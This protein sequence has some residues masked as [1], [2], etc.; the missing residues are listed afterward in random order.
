MGFDT[1]ECGLKAIGGEISFAD[2]YTIHTFK[3]SGTF[4]ILQLGIKNLEVFAVG[5]GGG[6]GKLEEID[7]QDSTGLQGCEVVCEGHGYNQTQ[8]EAIVG[9][10]YD[11]G[12][13]WS[14]S[15]IHI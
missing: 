11:D 3:E 8:C 9:C 2:G 14:L 6:G 13:C 5:G 12:K 15:L 7:D 1:G 4:T 10:G